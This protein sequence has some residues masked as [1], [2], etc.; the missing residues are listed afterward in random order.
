MAERKLVTIQVIK[1]LE[2]IPGAD[3]IEKA[4]VMGWDVVVKKGEFKVGGK[5]C[6]AE[7]D[8]VLPDGQS[9]AEF[10]RPR[11]FRVKTVKLRGTLSQGLA[12]PMSILPKSEGHYKI[13]ED[14]TEVLGIKK[15]EIPE[16]NGGAKMGKSAGNFPH[17][18]P[19]TD[20]IR[21]QSALRCLDE[22]R[23]QPY[24]ITLKCDGTSG[25][26]VKFEGEFLACSRNW[27]K[28]EDDENV[29]WAM[30]HKY[31]L[32]NKIPE[33]FAV[34]GEIIGP[35]IQANRLMLPEVDM[36]IFTV[37]D[38]NARRRVEYE[39]LV[40]F[41]EAIGVPMVPVL[42]EGEAFDYNLEQLLEKARGKYEGTKNHREGIVIRPKVNIY[43]QKLQG[44]LS[45]KCINNDYLLKFDA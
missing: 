17:Y 16:H 24:Y 5:C 13:G 41:C 36:R 43:S 18:V 19:K 39:Y 3:V 33:G 7:V 22:L 20:E 40:K 26:F 25:T 28:K 37:Y 27:A 35:G 38:I 15:Y 21:I 31:D 6:F 8:S 1:N 9:W 4:R 23:G 45:V 32:M 29:Y 42:E 30:A 10:M 34:Q 2:P 14:V 44:P 12:L 11:K